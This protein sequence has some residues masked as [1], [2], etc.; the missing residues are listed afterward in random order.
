MSIIGRETILI[1]N[2]EKSE[3]KVTFTFRYNSEIEL[4][5]DSTVSNKFV[6]FQGEVCKDNISTYDFVEGEIYNNICKS[7]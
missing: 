2:I 6:I 4:D 1:Y 3:K 5:D 7:Y